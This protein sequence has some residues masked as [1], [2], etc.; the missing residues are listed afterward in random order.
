LAEPPLDSSLRGMISLTRGTH[1]TV[2][3][4]VLTDPEDDPASVQAFDWPWDVGETI[5]PC[6]HCRLWRAELFLVDPDDAIW[7]REW[8]AVDC[9]IWSEI[10][11]LDA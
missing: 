5:W 3:Q 1:A 11:D 8:H 10:N 6:R 4:S 7:I 9:A 2:N